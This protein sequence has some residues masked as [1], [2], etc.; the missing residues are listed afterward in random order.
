MDAIDPWPP[1]KTR[2]RT[3]RLPL[4]TSEPDRLVAVLKAVAH[5][6][7]LRIVALLCQ[8]EHQVNALER[9]LSAPQAIV[10]QQLRILRS[11]G[12]VAVTRT[13]GFARYRLQ[14]LALRELIRFAGECAD[15]EVRASPRR[16]G[17]RAPWRLRGLRGAVVDAIVRVGN[18]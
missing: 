18:A 4:T 8:G 17:A 12:L 1:M 9:Q 13:G 11:Q 7:R 16:R 15:A 6:L 3:S 2:R 5:P 10:S 14:G